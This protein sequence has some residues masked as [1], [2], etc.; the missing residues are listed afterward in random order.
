[1]EAARFSLSTAIE[2]LL[3][4]IDLEQSPVPGLSVLRKNQPFRGV[5]G[6][7]FREG[8]R[9][10]HRVTIPLKFAFCSFA[11]HGRITIA[12]VWVFL[13]LLAN[14]QEER[15]AFHRRLPARPATRYFIGK[16]AH[17]A[18]CTKTG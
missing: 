17:H 5:S 7:G 10:R 18:D 14:A 11:T 2:L 13:S 8:V 12:S 15:E 4:E 9:M 6:R 3:A 16:E 1:L